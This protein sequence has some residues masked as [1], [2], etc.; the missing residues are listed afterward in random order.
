MHINMKNLQCTGS[1]GPLEDIKTVSTLHLDT[2][3]NVTSL[4]ELSTDNLIENNILHHVMLYSTLVS[5]HWPYF[6]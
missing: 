5:C 1:F 4:K 3:A 2:Y 6:W